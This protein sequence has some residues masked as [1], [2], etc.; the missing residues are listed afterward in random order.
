MALRDKPAAASQPT[1]DG[2]PASSQED[3]DGA[4]SRAPAID[5]IP[6]GGAMA[7]LQVLGSFF[8]FFNTW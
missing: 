5:T 1:G 8:L 6:N 2:N 7:W 4:D 3:A